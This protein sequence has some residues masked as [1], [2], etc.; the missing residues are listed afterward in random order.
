MLSACQTR[1]NPKPPLKRDPTVTN[2]LRNILIIKLDIVDA[3][4]NTLLTY[5]PKS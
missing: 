1:V 3:I 5:L 2:S 4:Q